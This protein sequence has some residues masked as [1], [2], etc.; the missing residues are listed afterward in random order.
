LRRPGRHGGLVLRADRR[1]ARAIPG[2]FDCFLNVRRV[3]WFCALQF[4]AGTSISRGRGQSSARLPAGGIGDSP[5]FLHHAPSATLGGVD[6]AAG[7][8]GASPGPGLGRRPEVAPRPAVLRGGYKS[9]LTSAGPAG[10]FAHA[11][12]VGDLVGGSGRGRA[13]VSDRGLSRPSRSPL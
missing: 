13:G 7:P 6:P 9:S 8:G 10:T 12:S 4:P 11:R 5:A 2:G 3:A 1:G